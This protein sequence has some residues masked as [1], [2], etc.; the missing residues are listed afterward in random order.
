MTLRHRSS[1]V[2]AHINTREMTSV[3][4]GCSIDP[5]AR[6]A[7]GPGADGVLSPTP[8]HPLST[9]VIVDP[10]RPFGRSRDAQSQVPRLRRPVGSRNDSDV[11]WT[12]LM[13]DVQR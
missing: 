10:R 8:S 11:V 7:A 13:M 12:R 2:P 9:L 6:Y 5:V 1:D 4:Y 3:E